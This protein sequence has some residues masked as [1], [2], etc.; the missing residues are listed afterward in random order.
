MLIITKDTFDQVRLSGKP[1][2]RVTVSKEKGHY[3]LT[4]DLMGY[5][6]TKLDIPSFLLGTY[7]DR[8]FAHKMLVRL[9]RAF[10]DGSA[11]VF[12]LNDF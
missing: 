12:N 6:S 10:Y 7:T 4:V 5:T 1:K 3:D 11:K 2:F 8:D 9:V